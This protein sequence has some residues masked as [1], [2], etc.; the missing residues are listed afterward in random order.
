MTELQI[1]WTWINPRRES[2]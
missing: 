2:G 1:Y